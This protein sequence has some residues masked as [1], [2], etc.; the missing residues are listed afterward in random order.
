LA[1]TVHQALAKFEDKAI[2]TEPA[3]SPP[4]WHL[5]KK[6]RSKYAASVAK[7]RKK[8][9]F[10]L[11]VYRRAYQEW[12]TLGN[13]L[14]QKLTEELLKDTQGAGDGDQKW[15]SAK[16]PE[17]VS[18]NDGSFSYSPGCLF[19]WNGSWFL[20]QPGYAML[21]MEW[22]LQPHVLVQ[23]VAVFPGVKH[24]FLDFVQLI[25]AV[26]EKFKIRE[27]SCCLEISLESTDTG[28]LHLHAF[29]ERNCR[30]DLAWSKWSVIRDELR[31]QGRPVSHFVP[32]GIKSRG[33][34][35]LR[36]LTEGHYYC[37]AEKLGHV[38]CE[39]T[40]PKWVKTFPDSRMITNL[41]RHRKMSTEA[42]MA[43]V[44]KSR[45]KVPSVISML[46]ATMSLEYTAEL[47][48]DAKHA[49]SS[50]Q[51]RPF[52][53]PTPQELL[54]VRQYGILASKPHMRGTRAKDFIRLDDIAASATLRRHKAL[55]YDGPSGLGK[56]E[57]ACSWFGSSNTLVCNAQDCTTP[58]LRYMQSGRFNCILFDEGNW[59]MVYHNKTM[60]QASSRAVELGQSQCNDRSYQV[61]LF[62]VPMI[63]ASNEFWKGSEKNPEAVAWVQANIHYVRVEAPVF[64]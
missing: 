41:W 62:R 45:D 9:E 56:T 48:V 57:L 4:A 34:G 58:N 50:W 63:I 22:L 25:S 11:D 7:V 27:W 53:D 51:K 20:D 26:K 60:M 17:G 61:L 35:R 43:E 49:D 14:R 8:D 52:K 15:V 29:F 64:V 44:L 16:P 54:W 6:A 28:R 1:P 23:Y 40:V 36:A 3:T 24:L 18:E 2:V 21:V 31:F 39:S 42:C 38:L 30:E 33:R 59:E 37:L 47:E 5:N 32:C 10:Y 19:T 46:Q 55:V 13:A 12:S